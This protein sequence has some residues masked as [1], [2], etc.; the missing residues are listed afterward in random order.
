M[1]KKSQKKSG[2]FSF[3]LTRP[4]KILIGVAIV[5]LLTIIAL[6]YSRSGVSAK[7]ST[8]NGKQAMN[9]YERVYVTRKVG[10][11]TV[12]IDP[13]TGQ[14][15]P[16]TPEEAKRL[17]DGVKELANQSTEGLKQ[18]Q[19]PD[20]TVS[21]DL[22]GRFQNVAV[23]RKEV[24]GTVTQSCIDNPQAGAAFFRLDPSSV[25]STEK[26]SSTSDARTPSNR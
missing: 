16:L 12:L 11:Q 22:E 18:V 10:N 8:T 23:A 15:K 20:G 9:N 17:A 7:D 26:T 14:L 19:H 5:A 6:G 24:D 25:S 4:V 3:P 21:V 1:K 2:L 13:Q